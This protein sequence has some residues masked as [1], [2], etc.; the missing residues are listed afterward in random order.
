[1]TS[2]LKRIDGVDRVVGITNVDEF[3]GTE[4]A[5]MLRRIIPEKLLSS[6]EMDAAK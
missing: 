4:D 3:F 1:L 5:V 6:Q 2:A